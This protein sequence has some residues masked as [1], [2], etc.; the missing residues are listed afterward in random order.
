[1]L[2]G[3]PQDGTSCAWLGYFIDSSVA[4]VHL[5]VGSALKATLVYTA[6]GTVSGTGSLASGWA[7]SMISTPASA[8]RMTP[9]P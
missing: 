6:Q 8:L 9:T 7:C 2:V 1:M 4:P 5:E 3:Q